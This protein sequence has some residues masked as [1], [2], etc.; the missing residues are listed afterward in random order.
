MLADISSGEWTA[1]AAAFGMVTTIVG[2]L[3][4][5]VINTQKDAQQLRDNIIKDLLPA[6]STMTVAASTV[7]QTGRDMITALAVAQA[8]RDNNPRPPR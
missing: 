5:L 7:T 1:V 4:K 8:R 3:I 6:M 2:G